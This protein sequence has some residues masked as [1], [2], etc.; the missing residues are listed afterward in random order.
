MIEL[1]NTTASNAKI[2]LTDY[3]PMSFNDKIQVKLLEPNLKSSSSGS[4]NFK[5][6]LNKQSIL[7]FDLDMAMGKSETITIKY[8]IE[9]PANKKIEFEEN[10]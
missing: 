4:N 7:E 6:R 10:L 9:H 5:C 2:S 8:I 3:V 1:K